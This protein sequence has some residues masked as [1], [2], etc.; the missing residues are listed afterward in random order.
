M[1]DLPPNSLTH[2]KRLVVKIG[3]ALLVD[4]DTG[5]VRSDW[6]ES[7]ALDLVEA[8]K[9]GQEVILVS[10][11]AIALGRGLLGLPAGKVKLEHKQAAAAAGQVILAQQYQSILAHHDLVAAQILITT[12]DTEDRRRHLNARTTLSALLN[13][14]AIPV[15][16]ENDTI[17]TSEIR[18]G[19]NDRLA[20]RVAQ[21]CSADALVLLSDVDGLYT[22]DPSMDKT[23][24]YI[25]H[26]PQITPAIEDIAGN[27]RSEYGSGGMVTKIAAAKIATAAGCHVLIG[28][29][30]HQRPLQQFYA[31]DGRY[32]WFEAV[33]E[34]STAR[35]RWL[36]GHVDVAGRIMIDDGAVQALHQGRSLLPAGITRVDGQF[37]RGDMLAVVNHEGVEIARGLTAYSSA[38]AQRIAGHQ[39]QE[40]EALLGF[41]GREEMIHRDNLVMSG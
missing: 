6:L 25:A 26:V 31:K 38:D 24:R 2:A 1:T 15:I 11:G 30:H 36:I 39:S 12:Q 20:A 21:M 34:P 8:R 35:K 14:G 5:R 33:A 27:S 7:L 17:A 10:S 4:R 32:T 9:R 23:A 3:S 22:A 19:D 16:N 28:A 13:L 37:D 29:G 18:F 41:A 40:I